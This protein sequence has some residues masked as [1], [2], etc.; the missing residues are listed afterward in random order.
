MQSYQCYCDIDNSGHDPVSSAVN[1]KPTYTG[2]SLRDGN[3]TMYVHSYY[4]C[5]HVWVV[6][7]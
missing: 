4:S 2:G 5:G 1:L 6:F 3:F 7:K